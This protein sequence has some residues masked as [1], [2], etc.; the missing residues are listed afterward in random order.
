MGH[1]LVHV[2]VDHLDDLDDLDDLDQHAL[3]YVGPNPQ[4]LTNTRI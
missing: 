4:V 2:E 1:Q 3:G